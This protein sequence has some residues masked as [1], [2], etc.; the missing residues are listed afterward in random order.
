MACDLKEQWLADR[1]SLSKGHFVRES[2]NGDLDMLPSNPVVI[3][4]SK[5]QICHQHS[6]ASNADDMSV[7]GQFA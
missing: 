5:S 4:T 2:A 6:S 7:F 1:F 3:D